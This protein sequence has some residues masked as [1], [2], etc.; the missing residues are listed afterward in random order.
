MAKGNWQR[1]RQRHKEE[2]RYFWHIYLRKKGKLGENEGER[3]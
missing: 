1:K 2:E 3:S